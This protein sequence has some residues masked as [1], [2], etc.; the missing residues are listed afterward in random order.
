MGLLLII[1]CLIMG[2]KSNTNE[3]KVTK[4]K[5]IN[6]S[7]IL[8]K[9][10][11][12]QATFEFEGKTYKKSLHGYSYV[13]STKN[14][15]IDMKPDNVFITR[16]LNDWTASSIAFHSEHE[17]LSE[18]NLVST[19]PYIKYNN[20]RV[21]NGRPFKKEKFPITQGQPRKVFEKSEKY[22]RYAQVFTVG[23]SKNVITQQTICSHEGNTVFDCLNTLNAY[24]QLGNHIGTVKDIYGQVG[25]PML[26]NNNRYLLF[27]NDNRPKHDSRIN[28]YDCKKKKM[29]FSEADI[30]YSNAGIIQDKDSDLILVGT[31]DEN[32]IQHYKAIDLKKKRL[33]SKC[34]DKTEWNLVIEKFSKQEWTASDILANFDFKTTKF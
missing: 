5:D 9:N 8:D 34:F 23:G 19:H 14:T 3:A 2:C 6:K 10:G 30:S 17:K 1:S 25:T 31:K 18:I 11:I 15:R 7:R 33:M 24:D 12:P 27:M 21:L 28:V 13:D 4:I 26:S 29:I 16:Y 32:C 20:K 22:F